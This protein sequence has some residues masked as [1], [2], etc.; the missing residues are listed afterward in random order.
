MVRCK[1]D[2]HSARC[3]ASIPRLL[4]TIQRR[5]H[6]QNCEYR[7]RIRATATRCMRARLGGRVASA[8]LAYEVLRGLVA[9]FV[10]CT[11]IAARSSAAASDLCVAERVLDRWA[12]MIRSAHEIALV[13]RG[14]APR[15]KRPAIRV[16]LARARGSRRTW[17]R[18]RAGRV[19][20]A[21]GLKFSIEIVRRGAPDE[22]PRQD[23][24]PR[25]AAEVEV[26]V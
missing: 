12:V 4:L 15:A 14:I 7:T 23:G 10:W 1:R 20:T 24:R 5:A 11:K 2:R 9:I 18:R 21:R 25:A 26:S 13:G 16:L 19:V 6:R 3:T 17:R 22:R 8:E